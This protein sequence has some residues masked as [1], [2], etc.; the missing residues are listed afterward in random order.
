MFVHITGFTTDKTEDPTYFLNYTTNITNRTLTA[1]AT[2]PVYARLIVW[3]EGLHME[4]HSPIFI[5]L[6]AVQPVIGLLMAGL[7]FIQVFRT[8]LRAHRGIVPQWGLALSFGLLWFAAALFPATG[9]ASPVNGLIAERWMYMPTMG[10][11]LCV[12]QIAA[13]VLGDKKNIAQLLVLVLVLSLST[14]TFF[15]NKVWRNPETLYFNIVKNN[16]N[17]VRIMGNLG[18][19]YLE[20]REFDKA[21]GLAQWEIKH[22]VLHVA[23]MQAA[24]YMQ[25]ALA[26]LQFQP[27]INGD[28]SNADDILRFVRTSPHLP[29]AIGALQQVLQ[30]DPDYVLAHQYLA[31]IYRFQGKHQMSGFHDKEA[32]E[33]LKQQEIYGQ[34]HIPHTGLL[35]LQWG[36]FDKA[37]EQ[38]QYEAEHTEGL[39]KVLKAEAHLKL[40]MA[41]LHI[42][43]GKDGISFN[44]DVNALPSSQHIP[45]AIAELKKATQD[46]P[47]FYF[48]HAVLAGLYRHQGDTLRADFHDR[49]A[50]GI[51]QRQ[52]NRGP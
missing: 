37:I 9:I 19:F 28:V 41:W 43:P 16:G 2:L 23:E 8:G 21:I 32:K 13:D 17:P 44:V 52:G 24:P 6:Q 4:W 3:P 49:Q 27:D 48:A 18:G 26:W 10:L 38:L 50:Q 15:Q 29:E 20:H 45:E 11:F 42:P 31:I 1:L 22:P 40:A 35:Y 7:G 5:G 39:T 12:A 33:I 36:E 46:N 47:D 14:K 51:L 30:I 34:Q 25:L